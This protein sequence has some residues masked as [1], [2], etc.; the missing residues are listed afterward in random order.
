MPGEAEHGRESCRIGRSSLLFGQSLLVYMIPEPIREA[1][2]DDHLSG[3]EL[4]LRVRFVAGCHFTS[5]ND[6]R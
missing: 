1:R 2:G 4:L 5:S 6:T 3:A